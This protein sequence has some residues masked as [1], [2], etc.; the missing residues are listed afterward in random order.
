MRAN[1]ADL[2]QADCRARRLRQFGPT[3][4][5]AILIILAGNLIAAPIS[6]L[7]VLVWARLSNTRWR[8]L[9]FARPTS[10]S[11]SLVWGTLLGIGLKFVMKALIMP[12]LGAPPVNQAYHYLA[13]NT[14]A[15]PAAILTMIIVAGFGE[16]TVYRG[17]LFERLG[18][19]LGT[20]KPA[21]LLTVAVT[22]AWFALLHYPEQGIPGVRAG[23]YY[24]IGVRNDVCHDGPVMDA[25]G[26]AR[27]LRPDGRG[28]DL[29]ERGEQYCSFYFS[30]TM[31]AVRTY[32]L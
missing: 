32:E 1:R 11:R 20:A 23:R 29:L 3:G 6:A 24:R 5:L 25:D 27:S 8:D 14:A 12:L 10:W 13:G 4:I 18:K 15:L 17:F 22:S 16:E 21:R 31:N 28:N 7:L 2:V 26:R 19:L 9:G 30:V